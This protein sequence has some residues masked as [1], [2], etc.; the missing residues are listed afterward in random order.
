MRL[1]AATYLVPLFL[2]GT[3]VRHLE[4]SCTQPALASSHDASWTGLQF[5]FQFQFPS[6]PS[7]RN[8]APISTF[9]STLPPF[10][11]ALTRTDLEPRTVSRQHRQSLSQ[12]LSRSCRA[13]PC[14]VFVTLTRTLEP[15]LL[16]SKEPA[17]HPTS[18]SFP[19]PP[20]C[21][22]PGS[23]PPLPFTQPESQPASQPNLFF[24][25]G[26][27]PS[28]DC[29]TEPARPARTQPVLWNLGSSVCT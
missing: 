22:R 23:Q 1:F 20:P 28:S 11:A 25:P 27:A 18:L 2:S 12:S 4:W 10:H 19:A 7:K 14:V 15:D 21:R 24:S 17:S 8:E 29:S 3:G 9:T 26:T 13:V 5:Q 6:S 16:D